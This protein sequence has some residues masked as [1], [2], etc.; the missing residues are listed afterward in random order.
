MR[1]KKGR[2]TER[3]TERLKAKRERARLKAKRERE[4]EIKR[5][6]KTERDRERSER[7]I[8]INLPPPISSPKKS[9]GGSFWKSSDFDGATQPR[10]PP[11]RCT[12]VWKK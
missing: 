8:E 10:L 12:R 9:L 5:K 4:R 7:A 6:A 1:E 11:R 3:Y 2:E